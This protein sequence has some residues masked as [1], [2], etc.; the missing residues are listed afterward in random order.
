V[1]FC[2]GGS[3]LLFGQYADA[4]SPFCVGQS[5]RIWRAEPICECRQGIY[6]PAV[7]EPTEV[8]LEP[9]AG[10]LDCLAGLESSN[11]PWAYNPRDND[12][13]PAYGL[14]QFK[15]FTFKEK[16]VD[17]FGLP[18]DIWDGRIQCECAARLIAL[19]ESWRWPPIKHCI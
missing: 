17:E 4:Q 1:G 2:V 8:I 11:N 10:V 14:L 19:G 12:G 13:L 6:Q 16:C 9:L 18:D 15:D 5:N 3:L 7:F